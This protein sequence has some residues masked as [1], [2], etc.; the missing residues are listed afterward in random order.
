MRRNRFDATSG[1]DLFL[2][3]IC[4]TFGGIVFISMLVV[5]L[6]NATSVSSVE[7]HKKTLHQDQKRFRELT[8][9]KAILLEEI[10]QQEDAAKILGDSSE[11]SDLLAKAKVERA[12]A[13]R[14]SQEITDLT[15]RI[16][17]NEAKID[18]M[19]QEKRKS[20][21][22][23]AEL[24]SLQ[25][26]LRREVEK[27]TKKLTVQMETSTVLIERAFFLSGGRLIECN[28][29]NVE[30]TAEGIVAK[31]GAGIP[32][33]QSSASVIQSQFASYNPKIHYIAIA[34]WEDSFAEWPLVQEAIRHEGFSYRLLLF[35]DGEKVSTGKTDGKVQ[36]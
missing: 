4:N 24:K 5:V 25:E 19:Y 28:A 26:Q 14:L 17:E 1:L 34:L 35:R 7:A 18:R 11:V 13:T 9:E 10:R 33:S 12:T 32:V 23:E 21:A 31:P 27:R 8:R 30:K 29:E 2:D 16:T 3:A 22:K 20:I 6:I 15:A 36:Q